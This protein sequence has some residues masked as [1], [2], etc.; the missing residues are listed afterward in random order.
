MKVWTVFRTTVLRNMRDR[1]SLINMLLLP[2]VLIFILGSALGGEYE[3]RDM[4][5]IPA[6]VVGHQPGTETDRIMQFF[7]D[8]EIRS[9]VEVR[10]AADREEAQAWLAEGKVRGVV[11]LDGY[12]EQ[13]NSGDAV[14]IELIPHPSGYLVAGQV[15]KTVLESFTQGAST[16]EALADMGDF[17]M[18]YQYLGPFVAEEQ[19]GRDSLTGATDYY[20][21]TM[22]VMIIFFGALYAS[23]GMA[24]DFTAP[25]GRRIRSTP[26]S[27]PALFA[28]KVLGVVFTLLWQVAA[29]LLFTAVVYDVNWGSDYLLLAVICVTASVF[30]TALGVAVLAA[31][32]DVKAAASVLNVLIP[33]STFVA[34]GYVRLDHPGPVLGFLQRISPNYLTQTAMF[35]TIYG[36]PQR[37]TLLYMASLWALI[38]ILFIAGITAMRRQA[39]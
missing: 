5:A 7:G 16:V 31:L 26:I 15:L 35:N 34:G 36:G 21:V 14:V 8:E 6:A 13:V 18:E 22:L 33:I 37:E 17:R 2:I 39:A 12:H 19:A 23:D 24:E 4:D 20:A 32:R 38:L 10:Q 27:A 3:P 9:L 30:A 28:G 25:V 29:L 11:V 1:G